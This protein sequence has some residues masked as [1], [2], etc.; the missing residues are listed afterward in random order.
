MQS[1]H[2]AMLAGFFVVV[3]RLFSPKLATCVA[4]LLIN[5]RLNA[6]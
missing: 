1:R 6:S 5:A 3:F 4:H 2:V